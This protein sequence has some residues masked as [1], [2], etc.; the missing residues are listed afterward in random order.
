[1]RVIA[2]WSHIEGDLAAIMGKLLKADVALTTAIYQAVVNQDTKRTMVATAVKSAGLHEWQTTLFDAVMRSTKPSREERNAFAHGVWGESKD[3]P[4]A[5]LLM[6]PRVVIDRNA[7]M[8]ELYKNGLDTISSASY[9]Y[10]QIMVYRQGDF[11]TAV[12]AAISAEYYHSMLYLVIGDPSTEQA[13]RQL[14]H[15]RPIQE[16]VEALTRESSP[17]LQ[18]QLRPPADDEPPPRGVH[19]LWD[20]Y[21]DRLERGEVDPVPRQDG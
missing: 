2:H 3:V 16:A 17:E 1:M 18:A 8:H 11:D 20:D 12:S 13:R 6:R 15:E 5:V 10:S 19:T 21:W 14:L 4:D 7:K 9:D